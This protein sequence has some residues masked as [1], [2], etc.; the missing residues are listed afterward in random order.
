MYDRNKKRLNTKE[1]TKHQ[2]SI[3]KLNLDYYER[4]N[5]IK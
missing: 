5:V 4:K 2:D 3:R 1:R